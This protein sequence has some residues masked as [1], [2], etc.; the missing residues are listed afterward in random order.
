M[1]EPT[2]TEKLF[3]D[4]YQRYSPA[5]LK[6]DREIDAA[7]KPIFDKWGDAGYSYREISHLVTLSST[8]LEC[9]NVLTM[10]IKKRK[11]QCG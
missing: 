7:L 4:K 9:E 3:D 2:V 10:A 11:Q 8:A 1:D 5:A 6:I